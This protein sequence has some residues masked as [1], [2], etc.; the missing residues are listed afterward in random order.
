MTAPKQTLLARFLSHVQKGGP[1]ECWPWS[2]SRRKKGGYGR[3]NV[4]GKVR[5]A[6]R[7]AYELFVGPIPFGLHVLHH[8]DNPPC[9]NPAHLYLGNDQRNVDDC[10]ARGR[11]RKAFGEAHGRAKL[12]AR[13]VR[14]ARRLYTMGRGIVSLAREFGVA[15]TTMRALVLRETWKSVKPEDQP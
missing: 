13:Q 4:N 8:C 3:L 5:S 10:R 2:G 11:L 15:E 14:E 9:V 6:S 7:V 12:T 1:D